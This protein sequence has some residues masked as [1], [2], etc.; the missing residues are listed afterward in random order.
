MFSHDFIAFPSK[1]TDQY[2]CWQLQIMAVEILWTPQDDDDFYTKEEMFAD[3]PTLHT[4]H[5][6]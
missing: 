1:A 2:G 5:N 3:Y 6:L 4:L